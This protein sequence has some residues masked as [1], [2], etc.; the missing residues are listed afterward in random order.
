MIR[1]LFVLAIASV[2]FISCGN[3]EN[4]AD[5]KVAEND[6]STELVVLTPDN[7]ATKAVDLVGKDVKIEGT[8]DHICKHGGKKMIIFG[9]D[10]DNRVKITTGEGMAAF[11]TDWN[12]SDVEVEGTVEEFRIDE[13]YL[14]NWE[15]DVQAQ[16]DSLEFKHNEETGVHKGEDEKDHTASD[17]LDQINSYR[18][19][20]VDSGVDHISFYSI[21]CKDYSIKENADNSDEDKA[22]A[23]T[24]DNK[25]DE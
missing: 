9:T 17:E 23:N 19:E 14:A 6:S 4:S 5:K 10:P 8:I 13:D 1:K 15:A 22:E 20:M 25:E 11:N 18:Q 16:M 24:E 21:V 12:G 7:F 2:F 3:Q